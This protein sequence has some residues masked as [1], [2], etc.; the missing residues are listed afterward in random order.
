M[1]ESKKINIAL[2]CTTGGHFEQMTNLADFYNRYNHFWVTQKTAQTENH[3]KTERKY[4]MEVA[5]FK[6]PWTYL[7]QIA[8]MLSV[9]GR[10]KP[11]HVLSTGSGRTAFIPYII[12]RF[13]KAN[14]IFID[15]MINIIEAI[16][17]ILNEIP[18]RIRICFTLLRSYK[19]L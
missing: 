8:P 6:R 1:R 14:F 19:N 7:W 18:H 16:H 4:F 9:F 12:S 11:T 13:W 5:H 15:F 10:E 2:V 3:L 17:E